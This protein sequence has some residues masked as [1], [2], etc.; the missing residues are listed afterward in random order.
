MQKAPW[1]YI[2]KLLETNDKIKI[3]KADREKRHVK[4][5]ETKIRVRHIAY[6]KQ[7][8]NTMLCLRNYKHLVWVTLKAQGKA[9]RDGQG[10]V[11]EDMSA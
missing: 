2:I 11:A 9:W 6:Q 5:R 10:A 3:L 1:R 4:Y 7:W 8:K